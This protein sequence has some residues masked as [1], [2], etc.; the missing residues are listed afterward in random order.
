MLS[1]IRANNRKPN[2][3]TNKPKQKMK[4]NTL[5]VA[6]AIGFVAASAAASSITYVQ[7]TGTAYQTPAI[8]TF[9]TYG[10]DMAG[11]DVW[12][13]F[14]D[15]AVEHTVWS[16]TGSDAGAATV[17]GYF[18]ISETGDTF[19]SRAWTLQNLNSTLAITSFTLLG[20]NGNTTFDRTFG[21]AVGTPNSALGKDFAIAGNYSVTATYSDILNLT[22]AAAVGDEFEQ[23]SVAFDGSYFGPDSS[24]L[25]TQDTDNAAVAGTIIPTTVPDGAS[26]A[27]LFGLSLTAVA[28]LKRRLA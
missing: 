19:S 12:V 15:G 4:I 18:S 9:N 22:G 21:G 10:S 26:T 28:V 7:D 5:L 27:M 6:T 25:F 24:A 14:S 16:V 8:S 11:M 13:T 20:V 1:R 2:N 3:Q 17:G 23:L